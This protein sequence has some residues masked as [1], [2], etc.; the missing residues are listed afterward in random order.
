MT[1]LA[2][3]IPTALVQDLQ[4][5]GFDFQVDEK[6]HVALLAAEARKLAS[7]LYGLHALMS[8]MG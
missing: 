2:G 3:H 5:C 8:F 4:K 6:A 7:L 1:T